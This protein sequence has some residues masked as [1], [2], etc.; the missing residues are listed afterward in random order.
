[1]IVR[2]TKHFLLKEKRLSSGFLNV[3]SLKLC[4]ASEYSIILCEFLAKT[5][6]QKPV[7]NFLYVVHIRSEYVKHSPRSG[8]CSAL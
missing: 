8:E 3:M 1:M 5:L 6:T 2:P 7:E 4:Q